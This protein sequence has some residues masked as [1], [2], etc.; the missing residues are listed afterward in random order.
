MQHCIQVMSRAAA[1]D[2][3]Y[4]ELDRDIVIV[5][6]TGY[7]GEFPSFADNPHIVGICYVQF[8]DEESGP[9]AM[10]SNEAEQIVDFIQDWIDEDV[11]IVV[12]CSAGISRSAGVAAA[13]MLLLNGDDSGIFNVGRYAPN[14][15]CY[16]KVLSAAGMGYSD[17]EVDRKRDEQYQLWLDLA[18]ENGLI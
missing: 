5:S 10:T 9:T 18:Y 6:I 8:D 13:L 11:D 14:M 16:R 1:I 15:N 4:A 7:G 12:H 17:E 2:M 3:S